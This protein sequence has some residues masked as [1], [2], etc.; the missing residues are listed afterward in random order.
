M[1]DVV[2][3]SF[4]WPRGRRSRSFLCRG[5]ILGAIKTFFITSS[6]FLCSVKFGRKVQYVNYLHE[7]RPHMD[8]DRLP[9]PKQV[10]E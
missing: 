6:R 1:R 5:R 2:L 8:L 3:K 7:L 9:I 4:W 10:K